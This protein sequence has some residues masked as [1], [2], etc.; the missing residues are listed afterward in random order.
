L[1]PVA[2]GQSFLVEAQN[3]NGKLT[4]HRPGQCSDKTTTAGM[5]NRSGDFLAMTQF[6]RGGVHR[7]R[8]QV[9]FSN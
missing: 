6:D 1:E 4:G 7:A 9:K 5:K 2:T 8:L 3:P